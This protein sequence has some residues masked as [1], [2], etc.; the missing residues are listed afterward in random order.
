MK[1]EFDCSNIS[2]LQIGHG[3]LGRPLYNYLNGLGLSQIQ[4]I[5][6]SKTKLHSEPNPG[7]I[8]FAVRDS[9]LSDLIDQYKSSKA[10]LVHFS[11]SLHF[12]NAIGFH[13]VH[14]FP[15]IKNYI[16]NF[17]KTFFTVDRETIDDE[18]LNHIFPNS[19][20]IEPDQKAFYHACLS[21]ACS[22]SQL[23]A[24][25]TQECFQKRLNMPSHVFLNLI[26][27]GIKNVEDY[28]ENGFSGPW[29]RGDSKNQTGQI[30]RLED[31]QLNQLVKIQEQLIAIYRGEDL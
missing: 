20:D 4:L 30:K 16:L 1:N 3:S 9:E 7:Y 25:I 23:I 28:G 31:Q 29:V 17:S 27:Q 26:Q 13:P 2:V 14:S 18:F 22:S 24:K 10:I 15:D 19:L 6:S 12:E 8:F 5:P 21:L 11:G